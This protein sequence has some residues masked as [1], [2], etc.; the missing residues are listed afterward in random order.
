MNWPGFSN[1]FGA[2]F[3][4]AMVPLI[5]L[6]FLKLKRPRLEVSSL[7]LWQSVVNDQRVNSPF[8]KFRRNL[9]LLLQLLLLA[10]LVAA[11][12]QPFLRADAAR[13]EY[14]PVLIDC[15]ASMSAVDESTGKSRL[16]LVRE[17]VREMIDGLHGDQQL[18][19]FSFSATGRRLT[20]F[21]NDR[22]VLTRALASLEPSHLPGQLDDVLRMAAAYTRTFTIEKVMILTDGNLPDQVDFELP[23][24]LD[25]KR[26]APGGPN[27]GITE[28][29][30]RRSSAEEWEVFVRVAGSSADIRS[31]ELQLFENGI[32]TAT[33][34][35]EVAAD[36]SQRLVFP[37]SSTDAVLLEARVVPAGF[38]ALDI[39]N[40]VWLTLPAARPLKIWISTELF[41][42]QH[43]VRVLPRIDLNTVTPPPAPEYDLLISDDDK[44]TNVEAPI[45]IFVG[46]IPSDLQPLIEPAEDVASVV[47]WNRTAP[48]LRHVQMTDV[49]I[50]EKP[51]FAP[52]IGAK[53]LEERGYEILVDGNT[54]PLLLQRREG[55]K[56][57]Y[58]FLFHTD[59]STLPYRLGFPIIAANAVEAA[60]K[61]AS[62][63]EVAAA[64]TGVLP[65]I[66]LQPDREYRVKNPAGEEV[67]F[68]SS[69][70]GVLTGV[71]AAHAGRYDVF[72]GSDLTTSIG[73]GLLNPLESSLQVADEVRFTELSVSST[74]TSRLESDQPLWWLLAML[75]FVL[76]L[77]E[78][79]YFQRGRGAM[80]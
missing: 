15:S 64:P 65:P 29:S 38:D 74:D 44:L 9:L 34:T 62:L 20:E 33:E 52:G 54:G 37:V 39:D 48:L 31:G 61:Q 53:D 28:M 12:M 23:F 4:L 7:A 21:T 78:W 60:L 32:R 17:Q 2:W 13:A 18:A 45:Q 25:I 76:M 66:S 58:W 71:P 41:S 79:W 16:D 22:R 73:T 77:A 46:V 50:G 14:L 6:Y 8:Q 43:A 69:T 70:T 26:I 3:F 19:L 36:E 63:S 11:L 5:I 67:T 55:L 68:R 42:W 59:R 47:D 56:I 30:A 57:S 1:L 24:G 35:I 27:I 75:A 10:L 49:Q 40:S 72:D 80:T 51:T